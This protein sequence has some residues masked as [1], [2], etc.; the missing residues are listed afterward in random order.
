MGTREGTARKPSTS[1]V[2][3]HLTTSSAG[4]MLGKEAL[5]VTVIVLL[6]LLTASEQ[7]RPVQSAATLALRIETA[8]APARRDYTAQAGRPH[9]VPS[10]RVPHTCIR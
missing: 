1:T 3:Q 9:G 5:T 2:R 4:S 6:M 8:L 10:V 7:V